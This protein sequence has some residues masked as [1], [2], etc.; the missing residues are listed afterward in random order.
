MEVNRLVAAGRVSE[1][2]GAP[3]LNT[4]RF[5]RTTGLPQTG[6]RVWQEVDPALKELLQAYSD[7]INA[8]IDL[9]SFPVEFTLAGHTPTRWHPQ[10]CAKILL[11]HFSVSYSHCCVTQCHIVLSFDG[12]AA[13]CGL[14]P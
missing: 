14:G 10:K 9:G 7:G 8:F 3:G 13:Q 1:L 5:I 11:V 2:V 12:L 6:L 4:D